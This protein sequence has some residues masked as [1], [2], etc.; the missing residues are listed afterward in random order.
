M[1]VVS[2]LNM[3]DA[4]GGDASSTQKSSLL[5][6]A[7]ATGSSLTSNSN[8]DAVEEN[9]NVGV[10]V[11]PMAQHEVSGCKWSRAERGL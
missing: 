6:A 9:I 8:V 1:C 2:M 3:S 5:E 4:S 11:R 10:R 7:N